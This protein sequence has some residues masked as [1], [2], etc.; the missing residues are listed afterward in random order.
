M[1]GI[2]VPLGSVTVKQALN[3]VCHCRIWIVILRTLLPHRSIVLIHC[4]AACLAL[5]FAW[6][7]SHT[8]YVR[9]GIQFVAPLLIIMATH[10][11]WFKLTSGLTRGFSN[12]IYRRSTQTAVGM[13][14][15][16]IVSDSL[17][18]LPAHAQSVEGIA[19]GIFTV[20]FC[21]S[22]IA[23]IIAVFALFIRLIILA[24]K[25]ING[26]VGGTESPDDDS[27][28]NDFGSLALVLVITS[29]ASLEGLKNT[30]NFATSGRVTAQ[31]V[32][33]APSTK[34]WQTMEQA[35]SPSFALPNILHSFPKPVEV[36]VDEGVGLGA[37]RKVKFYGR[38]G[39]GYLTLRVVE[40]TDSLTRFEVVSDTSPYAN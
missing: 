17:V 15:I 24:G 7:T 36:V 33:A 11:V 5:L 13:A 4:L 9:T 22:I 38:E 39:V 27:T 19:F 8:A 14:F 18:P 1:T 30:Y 28:T 31:Q 20:V 34:V 6:K 21:G 37:V 35:T 29:V 23:I 2:A 10:F 40:R 12:L 3:N 16:I 26:L 25:V 32:I